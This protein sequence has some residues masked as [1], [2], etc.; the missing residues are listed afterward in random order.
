MNETTGAPE[1]A[2]FSVKV[3]ALMPSRALKGSSVFRGVARA[4]GRSLRVREEEETHAL[5]LKLLLFQLYF[6]LI[7]LINVFINDFSFRNINNT[8]S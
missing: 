5:L 2:S 3:T 1:P 6:N 7:L 4:D 8:H